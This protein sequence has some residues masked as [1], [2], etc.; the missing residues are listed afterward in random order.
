MPEA[1]AS[2]SSRARSLL[3]ARAVPISSATAAGA[4]SICDVSARSECVHLGAGRLMSHRTGTRF[5]RPGAVAAAAP[6]PVAS[7]SVCAC[8]FSA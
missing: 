3:I 5:R 8:R 1:R 6:A 7:A 4:E 2:A